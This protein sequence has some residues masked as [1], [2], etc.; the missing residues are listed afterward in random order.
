MKYYI[1]EVKDLSTETIYIPLLDEGTDVFRPAKGR[2]IED[3]V[4][5]VIEP[6]DYDSD[7]EK[8]KFPPGSI[9]KCQREVRGEKV[10]IIVAIKLDNR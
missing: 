10:A 8:W 2:K 4:Y 1:L 7:D 3:M 5:E 9:V 6:D